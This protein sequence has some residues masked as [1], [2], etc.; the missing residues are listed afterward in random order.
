MFGQYTIGEAWSN[1]WSLLY[2]KVYFPK[3]R[4]IRQPFHLR[5]VKR[6]FVY[7][8]GLTVG[9]GCRVETVGPDGE[10]SIGKN[11]RLG[12]HVHLS[13]ATR[14]TIGDECLFASNIFVSDNSHGS[15]RGLNQSSPN[16]PPRIRPVSSR[17][18]SIGSNVWIGEGAAI[19]EGAMIGDG[20]IIGAHALV[21]GNIPSYSIAVGS[22]ARVIKRYSFEKEM[23]IRSDEDRDT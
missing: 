11:C 20:S 22:P 19:L 5:G 1:G 2:T 10:I 6:R 17:E 21:K 23:W 18:V 4:L 9:Y 16:D 15:Y 8:E 12:D 7:G 13:A 3:A 14:L